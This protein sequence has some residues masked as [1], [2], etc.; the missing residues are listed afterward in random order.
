MFTPDSADGTAQQP[1]G[2]LGPTRGTPIPTTAPAGAGITG[3]K[4]EVGKGVLA[5][6]RDFP[7]VKMLRVSGVTVKRRPEPALLAQSA[8]AL[9][10]RAGELG[11]PS[12]T[13]TV[14]TDPCC[15]E[16]NRGSAAGAELPLCSLQPR[17]RENRSASRSRGKLPGSAS[18]LPMRARWGREPQPVWVRGS[19][20]PHGTA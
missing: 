19:G 7:H 17:P 20:L 4:P 6:N 3:L 5:E 11:L 13:R 10:R 16:R 15:C 14:S 9:R 12:G 1:P 18:G 8:L 2:S